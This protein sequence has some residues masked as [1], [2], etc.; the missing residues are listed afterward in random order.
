MHHATRILEQAGFK[1]QV[2]SGIFSSNTVS[3]ESPS[4]QAPQGSTITLA[5][6][7]SFP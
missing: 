5:L 7:F 6:G 1:V 2:S 4:G 3:G